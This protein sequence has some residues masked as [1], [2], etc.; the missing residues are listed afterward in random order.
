MESMEKIEVLFEHFLWWE[1][2]HDEINTERTNKYD[3]I[4][5]LKREFYKECLAL[6][7]R[8]PIQFRSM[9]ESVEFREQVELYGLTAYV[10][11]ILS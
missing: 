10:D 2:H 8:D 9:T 4:D 5:E 1:M 3:W 7:M 6:Y 11:R